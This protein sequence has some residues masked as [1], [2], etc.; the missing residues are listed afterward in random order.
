MTELY[1]AHA[2]IVRAERVLDAGLPGFLGRR[3]VEATVQVPDAVD[4][5][6]APLE[7]V[8]HSL[9]GRTGIAA[10]L[11]SADTVEDDVNA[12]ARLG[13]GPAP[14]RQAVSTESP[15][16]GELL[17]RLGDEVRAAAVP[18]P[19]SA[20]GDLV[21]VLG[22]EDSARSVCRAMA[23]AAATPGA[24]GWDLYTAGAPDDAAAGAPDDAAAGH[25]S[26]PH[27]VGW[28]DTVQA[29]A[30]AV[31]EG[32]AVLVACDLGPIAAGLPHLGAATALGPD[33]V[34]LV[35]D[36]RHKADETTDWV[37]Q[38]RRTVTVD[39]L[40]VIGAAESRSARTVNRLGIPLGWVDGRPAPWTV[41]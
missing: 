17:T 10:L 2:R 16:F 34:W 13:V 33:Q 31:A 20:P 41:L 12:L 8:G 35:V 3:H 15:D 36:A 19:L 30:L 21:L 23:A 25:S 5:E 38:V 40:A 7:P 27:L 14:P 4:L 9:A 18:T 26:P 28:W 6:A 11:E 32:T 1:G 37:D 29:R 24:G 39:A 22:L